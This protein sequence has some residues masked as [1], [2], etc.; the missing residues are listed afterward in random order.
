MTVL[1]LAVLASGAGTNLQAL[2]DAIASGGFAAEIVGV[3]SDRPA[4]LAMRRAVE[5]GLPATA[6]SP[7][8]FVS[9][10]AFD[11][12]FFAA[13]DAARPDLIVCAG[14]MRLIA[15]AEVEAR[16]DRMINLHPSLLPAFKGLHT[17]QQALDACASEHG[18]SV[19]I[20]TADLDDGP[21]IAQARVPV[22]PGDTAETLAARVRELEHPLLAEVVRLL[23]EHRLRLTN[24]RVYL[25]GESL[26]FPL[27]LGANRRLA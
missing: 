8:A 7:R 23:A 12:A 26:A 16:P 20:V 10:E 11:A 13:V 17:Y 25:N 21:V 19:H 2:I 18:A 15:A 4:C 24:G 1:R 3:F 14:Y 27:Q 22:L 5:A 9:R 6:L